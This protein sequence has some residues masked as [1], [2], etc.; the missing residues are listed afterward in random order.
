[1]KHADKLRD[2]KNEKTNQQIA[3]ELDISYENASV[4]LMRAK[5]NMLNVVGKRKD[6]V[7]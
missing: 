2:I 4:R 7:I 5:Q 3:K 6:W 1:M